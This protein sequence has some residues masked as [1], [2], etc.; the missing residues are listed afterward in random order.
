[1][2]DS[3]IM[4]WSVAHARRAA[5]AIAF[6]V[7]A[8]AFAAPPVQDPVEVSRAVDALLR[9]ESGAADKAWALPPEQ[10]DLVARRLVEHWKRDPYALDRQSGAE[11]NLQVVDG[12][13]AMRELTSGRPPLPSGAPEVLVEEL[14]RLV[15]QPPAADSPQRTI[16]RYREESRLLLESACAADGPA[17][18]T[19]RLGSLPPSVSLAY[20]TGMAATARQALEAG[21]PGWTEEDGLTTL[22]RVTQEAV[23][24]LSD[25]DSVALLR[26]QPVMDGIFLAISG[27]ATGTDV[28]EVQRLAA[29]RSYS[30]LA[31]AYAA[32]AARGDSVPRRF[33]A[34]EVIA[35]AGLSG[36]GRK[37]AEIFMPEPQAVADAIHRLA[38]FRD[39]SLSDHTLGSMVTLL[40]LA[41]HRLGGFAKL[42]E[43]MAQQTGQP[44]QGTGVDKICDALSLLVLRIHAVPPSHAAWTEENRCLWLEAVD[45]DRSGERDAKCDSIAKAWTTA[46]EDISAE[47]REQCK[48]KSERDAAGREAKRAGRKARREAWELKM[49][50]GKTPS[51]PTAK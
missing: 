32:I 48:T 15:C 18:V 12:L 35:L 17:K 9:S 38:G 40:D 47:W 20:A 39:E 8:S 21:L 22:E 46:R 13:R 37:G 36:Y 1:M 26:S 28:P 2:R 14:S 30:E 7:A 49:K 10:L 16:G 19:E 51:A 34:P 11:P 44:G 45:R 31:D 23:A 5:C 4:M 6:V 25:P 42:R 43:Q 33:S 41:S 3:R 27:L 24:F 29:A 50:E